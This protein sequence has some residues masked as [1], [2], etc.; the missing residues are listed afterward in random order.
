GTRALLDADI[1]E[2]MCINLEHSANTIANVCVGLMLVRITTSSPE[3]FFRYTDEARA[4]YWNPIEQQAEIMRRLGA[5]MDP[6]PENGWLGYTPH[7]ELP[8][9]PKICIDTIGKN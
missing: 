7:P 4:A 1:R 2:D 3:L 5:S 6:V 9:F 8:G